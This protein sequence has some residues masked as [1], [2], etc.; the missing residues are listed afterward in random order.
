MYIRIQ[1]NS[2]RYR[3]SEQ[4]AYSLLDGEE[5]KDSLTVTS[6]QQLHYSIKTNKK[7]SFIFD[8]TNHLKLE[9]SIDKLKSEISSRPSK[10][11]VLIDSLPAEGIDVYLEIDIKRKR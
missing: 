10:K 11:G 2:I 4:E 9:I 3:V 1:N 6:Q 8:K 7:D 5:L